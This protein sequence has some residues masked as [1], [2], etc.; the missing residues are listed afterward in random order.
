MVSFS[1]EDLPSDM[2]IDTMVTIIDNDIGK[3]YSSADCNF[4]SLYILYNYTVVGFDPTSYTVTEGT[5]P[6]VTL[7]VFRTGNED[8]PATVNFATVP[9]TADGKDCT[10][11]HMVAA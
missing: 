11:T 5:D 8:L 6:S 2:Q 9:G 4:A 10:H 7:T 1:S 3:H